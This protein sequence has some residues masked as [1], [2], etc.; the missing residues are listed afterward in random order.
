MDFIL[1]L[2]S[3][4]P[5]VLH[6]GRWPHG[7]DWLAEAAIDTYL[8]LTE[9]LL[10]LEHQE[11]PAPVTLGV[12]P[13]LANQLAH[14]T[15]AREI[16]EFLQQRLAATAEAAETL[17]GAEDGALAQ[18]AEWWRERF[19]RLYEDI[20]PNPRYIKGSNFC[21]V[22]VYTDPRAGWVVTVAAVDNLVKGAAGQA[23]QAMNLM[24]GIP[25]ESGL[26]MPSSYP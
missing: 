8:P 13:V 26:T 5:W 25:E 10:A 22:G 12:T 21:D 24:M 16:E 15:F 2:H 14:P 4:L 7:S 17:R 20:V 23:I 9:T 6:H 19:V 1:T 18:L 11:I 3:H